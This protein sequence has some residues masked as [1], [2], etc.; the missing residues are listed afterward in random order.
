MARE[1]LSFRKYPAIC[2]LETKH[3]VDLGMNYRTQTV[4]S[5]FIHYSA[6]AIRKELVENLRKV[7]FFT[8]LLDG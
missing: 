2:E 7:K 4:G 5:L 8:L 6:E 3:G 1:N